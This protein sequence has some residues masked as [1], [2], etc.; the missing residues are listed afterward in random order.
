MFALTLVVKKILLDVSD[1]DAE[2]ILLEGVPL[3]QKG[4]LYQVNPVTAFTMS[5][6]VAWFA[7]KDFRL[8]KVGESVLITKM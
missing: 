1:E 8:K 4:N 6:I 5:N 7:Q 3:V 2:S